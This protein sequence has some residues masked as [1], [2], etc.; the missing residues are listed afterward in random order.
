MKPGRAKEFEN[1][2]LVDLTTPLGDHKVF[3]RNKHYTLPQ[4][5][6]EH[7]P[8]Q[9]KAKKKKKDK[10]KKA[11]RH[12]K[13]S[14]AVTGDLLGFESLGFGSVDET[15]CI[16]AVAVNNTSNESGWETLPT[17]KD[18]SNPINTAFDDLLGLEMPVESSICLSS[19]VHPKG[20]NISVDQHVK[21]EKK[22]T[23]K[24]K[25]ERKSKD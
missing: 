11:S 18:S 4:W 10:K 23:K 3:P 5:H 13:P 20:A 25:K 9:E 17:P 1:L 15:S 12:D 2:A 24:S 22:N 8:K 21:K 16:S 7:K 6:I 14:E 19:G